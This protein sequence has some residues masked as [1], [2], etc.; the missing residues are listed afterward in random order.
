MQAASRSACLTCAATSLHELNMQIH[1]Q[2][3]TY[4]FIAIA[5]TKLF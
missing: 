2:Y 5:P 3:A 4:E 1:Y